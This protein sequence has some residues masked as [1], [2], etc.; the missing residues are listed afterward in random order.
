MPAGIQNEL[1]FKLEA[2]KRDTS[3]GDTVMFVYGY[4]YGQMLTLAI[5][6]VTDIEMRKIYIPPGEI[7]GDYE[8]MLLPFDTCTWIAIAVTINVGFVGIL[9]IKCLSARIQRLVFGANNFSLLMNFIDILINGGQNT[10]LVQNASR[11]FLLNFMIW[12][13][14]IRTCYQSEAFENLQQLKRKPIMTTLESLS[15]ANFTIQTFFH[16]DCSHINMMAAERGM[17]E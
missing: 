12:S 10:N 13:L 15:K 16:H 8:K 6:Y 11:F 1:N 3:Y 9:I 2:M 17:S 5:P 14:I 4:Y 7:Y